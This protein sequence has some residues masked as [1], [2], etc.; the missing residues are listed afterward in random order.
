VDF[1][2]S[3]LSMLEPCGPAL[4][5]RGLSYPTPELPWL[6]VVAVALLPP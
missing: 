6:A 5:D 2:D 1:Q 4:V 3:L